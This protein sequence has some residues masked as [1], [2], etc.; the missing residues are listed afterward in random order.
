MQG[1]ASEFLDSSESTLEIDRFFRRAN[2]CG[3]LETR[4]RPAWLPRRENF[5]SSTAMASTLPWP[6]ECPWELKLLGYRP[7]QWRIEDSIAISRMIG[8][9]TLSQSQA[10][11]ERLIVEMVQAGISRSKLDEL[12]PGLL[13]GLDVEL[14]K[15]VRLHHRV[16]PP[17]VKWGVVLPRMMASNN[18]VVAGNK[19]ASGKPILANDP[20]LEGNRLPNVWC[21]VVLQIGDRYA[22]GGSMPGAPGVL[23]GR[24]NDVAWGATY[25]FMD[26]VDSWIERCQDGKYYREPDGWLP[27]RERRELIKRKRKPPSEIT[28][29][30][31]EHG[32]LD[33]DPNQQGHYLCTRWAA[34]RSGGTTLSQILKMWSVK[35]VEQGM[36]V[37]GQIE[38]AWNF[39]LADR[40]GNI[41]YQMSG[42]LPKRRSG[43]QRPDSL[44]GLE[45]RERLEGIHQPQGIASV[46]ESRPRLLRHGQQ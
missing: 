46:L 21:E 26:S 16:V 5:C 20:H 32:V 42:L 8:Y 40:H 29:Y 24:T 23:I 34:G 11:M 1:R 17:E 19:T 31:N 30:E 10:E 41:G 7:E 15:R 39:V 35:N 22:M 13:H 2:W 14:I 3:D 36:D 9:L 33:G 44:A 12:F 27:F 6:N 4:S 25:T 38:T 37:L 45:S 43:R 18:W 28:F